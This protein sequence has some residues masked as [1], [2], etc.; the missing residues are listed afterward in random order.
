M[1]PNVR[2]ALKAGV[3]T[4]RAGTKTHAL[5]SMTS[6]IFNNVSALYITSICVCLQKEC[7]RSQPQCFTERLPSGEGPVAMSLNHLSLI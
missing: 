4:G 1:P 5:T 6:H 2:V 7:V 3:Q